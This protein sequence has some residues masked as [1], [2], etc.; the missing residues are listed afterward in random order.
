MHTTES[1]HTLRTLNWLE[2]EHRLQTDGSTGRI[3]VQKQQIATRAKL[4]PALISFHE[5]F[6]K[7]GLP[8]VVPLSGSSCGACH[9]KL[10]S[11]A[12]SELRILGRYVT[13]A[14]CSVVVWSAEAAKV[15]S[16]PAAKKTGRKKAGA[17]SA[18]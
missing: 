17:D 8:S 6:A 11:A 14:N 1:L 13:C 3:L 10:P 12:L 15:E 4:S 9:L 5:R 18:K 2:K 7:R 16:P